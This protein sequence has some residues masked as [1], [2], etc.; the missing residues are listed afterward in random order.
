LPRPKADFYH[1][2]IVDRL[3]ELKPF[4]SE[5]TNLKEP[6]VYLTTNKQ[7][8]LHYIKDRLESPMLKICDDGKIIFQEMF[9]GALKFL[10]KGKSGYIYHC[11]GDY[12]IN[13]NVGIMGRSAKSLRYHTFLH[14]HF[15]DLVFAAQSPYTPCKNVAYSRNVMCHLP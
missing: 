15:P 13:R 10:Y 5:N 4:F 3:I 9:S 8:A 12:E 2:T 11:I 1:G 14:P 7:L 6:V